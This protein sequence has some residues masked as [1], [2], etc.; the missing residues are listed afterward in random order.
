MAARS[1]RS[2]A[3]LP[4]RGQAL[5]TVTVKDENGFVHHFGDIET[6]VGAVHEAI[7][8]LQLKSTALEAAH[9]DAMTS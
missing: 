2:I 7:A 4:R 9:R 1:T 5:V 6:D 3:K 8:I